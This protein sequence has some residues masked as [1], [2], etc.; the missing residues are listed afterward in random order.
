MG[1]VLASCLFDLALCPKEAAATT[2]QGPLVAPNQFPLLPGAV[3]W[4]TPSGDVQVTPGWFTEGQLEGARVETASEGSSQQQRRGR[5]QP[6][7]GP[8]LNTGRL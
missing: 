2:P 8:S 3:H 5:P 7:E 6:R 4:R 1:P